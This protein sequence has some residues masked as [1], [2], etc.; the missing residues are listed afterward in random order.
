M[1]TP[2]SVACE[3]DYT[4]SCWF[5]QVLFLKLPAGNWERP[6]RGPPD[7]V[8][9]VREADTHRH[10]LPDFPG[11]L[12][13]GGEDAVRI[14]VPLREAVRVRVVVPVRHRQDR[15]V[16]LRDAGVVSHGLR[17]AYRSGQR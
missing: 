17:L 12:T 7:S 9:L 8:R 1:I 16:N 14:D 5:A 10:A 4:R 6:P 3:Y 15:L 2:C 11:H 13:R